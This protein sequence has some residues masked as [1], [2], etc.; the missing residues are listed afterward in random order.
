MVQPDLSGPGSVSQRTLPWQLILGSKLAISA[1]SP[2]FVALTFRKG[3]EY[4]NVDG[5]LYSCNDLAILCEN[6]MNFGPVTPK[7]TRVFGVHP[8]LDFL[9]FL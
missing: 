4:H 1:C 6:L 8:L 9:T 5:R 7:F 3:L 2:S